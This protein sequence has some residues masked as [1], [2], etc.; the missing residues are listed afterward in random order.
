MSLGVGVVCSGAA[1]GCPIDGVVGSTSG[2]MTSY[3]IVNRAMYSCKLYCV[4]DFIC[5]NVTVL[6]C[7]MR[8]DHDFI[9]CCLHR[10]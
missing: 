10:Y 8:G 2:T 4:W 3:E 9:L 6:Y 5:Y 7:C 1:N